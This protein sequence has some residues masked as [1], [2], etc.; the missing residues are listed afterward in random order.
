MISAVWGLFAA[1]RGLQVVVLALTCWGIWEGNNAWQRSTGR[2]EGRSEITTQ[3]NT[4]AEKISEKAVEN[5]S[6][7]DIP[8]ALAKLLKRSCRDCDG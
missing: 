4:E 5:R 8:D 6:R 7:G 2:A 1:S 3:T